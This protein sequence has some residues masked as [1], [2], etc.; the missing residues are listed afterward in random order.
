MFAHE[1]LV[2]RAH[3]VELLVAVA[4]RLARLEQLLLELVDALGEVV[5]AGLVVR[6]EEGVAERFAEP[7]FERGDVAV[8]FVQAALEE[9]VLGGDRRHRDRRSRA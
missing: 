7:A 9:R 8:A 1:L 6:V 2:E 4:Q 3:G 5:V